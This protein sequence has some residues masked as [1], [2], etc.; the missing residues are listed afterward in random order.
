METKIIQSIKLD[1]TAYG[2]YLYIDESGNTSFANPDEQHVAI[3]ATTDNGSSLS[4]SIG[5][6]VATNFDFSLSNFTLGSGEIADIRGIWIDIAAQTNNN[7]TY[8]G[9]KVT[10]P[11]DDTTYHTMISFGGENDSQYERLAH[12]FYVPVSLDQ[13]GV[14]T[15]ELKI[16]LES[17][18]GGVQFTIVGAKIRIK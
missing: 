18:T 1:E 15:P 8:T 7:E 9:A 14:A 10:M 6:Y 4:G 3:T 13:Y 16:Q 12:L 2:K 5:A 11:W 17:N